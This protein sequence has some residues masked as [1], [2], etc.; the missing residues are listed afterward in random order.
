MHVTA[1]APGKLMLYGEHA[2]VY[3]H[4]GIVTAV[5]VRYRV[6]AERL[7]APLLRITTPAAPER[8]LPLHT[9]GRYAHAE[10]AFVE[11]A[12]RQWLQRYPGD[13]GFHI[14]TQ[15]PPQGYGLG[16]SSAITAAT[17][18]ATARLCGH[19]LSRPELYEMARAAVLAVQGA[20]SG[21]DVAAAVYG[22]TCYLERAGA[23]PEPLPVAELPLVI[24]YSGNKVSTTALLRQVAA[25]RARQPDLLEPLFALTGRIAIRARA[26]LLEQRWQDL[27]A[28][29]N[30]HQGLLD[31]L[32]V[33]TSGLARLVHAAREAGAWGAKL[34]GAGGGDCMF[35]L[36]DDA[37]RE[38]VTAQISTAGGKVIEVACAAPGVQCPH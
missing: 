23:T 26:C 37:A 34:S 21:L 33:S 12:L 27:G 18:A 11:A 17:L 36:V 32:G 28:L 6:R 4:P 22:G 3:G 31:A 1:D 13:D 38:K 19:T 8:E 10:T 7:T 16:S 9:S 14:R 5:D 20:G 29:T 30:I 35:A 15:G 24:G 2:V 25:L